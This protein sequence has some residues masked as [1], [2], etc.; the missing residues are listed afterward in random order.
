VRQDV[1][2][3]GRLAGAMM[4]EALR[5]RGG[6]QVVVDEVLEI[7]LQERGSTSPLRRRGGLTPAGAG[8]GSAPSARV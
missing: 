1:I 2:A 5:G 3:Q 8:A 7:S 6:E 4:L